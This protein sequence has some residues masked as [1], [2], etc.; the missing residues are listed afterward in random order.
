[1]GN[2]T[3]SPDAK[4]GWNT[5]QTADG[6]FFGLSTANNTLIIAEIGDVAYDFAHAAQT[7]PTIYIQSASQSATQWGSLTHDQTDFLITSGAGAVRF[8][9]AT[10]ATVTLPATGKVHIDGTTART[11]T[12]EVLDIDATINTTTATDDVSAV[13]I[14]AARNSGDTGGTT[15]LYV[16]VTT[17]AQADTQDSYGI[18]VLINDAAC[19]AN[20][21][22]AIAYSAEAITA[23]ANVREIAFMQKTGWDFAFLAQDGAIQ[24]GD[25]TY[26]CGTFTMIKGAQTSD[27]QV[28]FALSADGNGNFSITADTGDITLTAADDF[29]VSVDG[30]IELALTGAALY[31]QSDG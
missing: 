19:S 15:G 24:M 25:A 2:T 1:M 8:A 12:T 22:D 26:D 27:P 23:D 28:Q 3:A 31:P 17:G 14:T 9:P 5:T 13:T 7:N 4:L 30:N 21:S 18:Q 29:F 20:T 10:N 16:S 6:V 11:G